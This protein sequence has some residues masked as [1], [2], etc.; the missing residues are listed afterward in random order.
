MV[1]LVTLV[2]VLALAHPLERKLLA[3]VQRR[4]GHWGMQRRE[5]V[6][7]GLALVPQQE[8]RLLVEGPHQVMLRRQHL[9]WHQAALRHDAPKAL[10]QKAF[11][12][13]HRPLRTLRRLEEDGQ[14]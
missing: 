3:V 9:P 4:P 13:A 1:R 5:M 6:V 2:R 14:C 10:V 12:Q 8:R 11:R 7:P